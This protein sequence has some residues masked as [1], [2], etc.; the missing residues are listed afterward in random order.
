VL[1]PAAFG[2]ACLLAH[3]LTFLLRMPEWRAPAGAVF[4]PSGVLLA[5]LLVL[6]RRRWWSYLLAAA[7]AA[8]VAFSTDRA[9]GLRIAG[10]VMPVYFGVVTLA[11]LGIRRYGRGPLLLS[12]RSMGAHFFFAFLL[13]PL[14]V[15][16]ALV[17]IAWSAGMIADPILGFIQIAPAQM[18]GA[19]VVTPP[20]AL[21]ARG[22]RRWRRA[23]LARFAEALPLG[24]GLLLTG[25]WVFGR[26]SATD[27]PAL[28]YV[29][30]PF[31]LWATMRFGV[32]GTGATLFGLALVAFG[33]A[34]RGRGPFTA[35]T[36]EANVQAV[37]LL[38]LALS[39][40]L[41]FLAATSEER[42]RAFLRVLRSESALRK[43]HSE[44][45]ELAGR[46]LSAQE[47]ERMRLARELHDDLG[48]RLAALSIAL[49]SLKHG[50]PSGSQELAGKLAELQQRTAGLADDVQH[51]S[52]DL[53]PGI[54]RHGGLAAALRATCAEL[55]G[56]HGLEVSCRIEG[57]AGRVPDA[58]ALCLF[59][60]SQ[61]ALRNVV[62]H[63][64]AHSAVVTL[65]RSAS[66]V[67]LSVRDDGCGFEPGQPRPR[68]GLGLISLDERVRLVG[69]RLDLHSAPGRGTELLV[70]VPIER[71][72]ATA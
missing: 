34:I 58:I 59:R 44:V 22:W 9:A 7:A 21:A 11:A 28:L 32:L 65:R 49:S 4:V 20:L 8:V 42:R 23:P 43:S 63:A 38:F 13:L 29:P 50:L 35:P 67:S 69:G 5:A 62:R 31:L 68:A 14:V 36:A 55:R 40:P 17:P 39:P 48:Q 24:A 64:R 72:D 45:R 33:N 3:R 41:F 37:Q 27:L 15:A 1:V 2:V 18:L 30:V 26:T 53:H 16:A 70:S 51:L 47:D 60:V 12:L 61:E 56:S 57:E 66:A 25:Q 54:L 19:F 71:S 52:H 10:P 46:L 6:P